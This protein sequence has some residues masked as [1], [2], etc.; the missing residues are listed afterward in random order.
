MLINDLKIIEELEIEVRLSTSVGRSG[1]N[2]HSTFLAR[3]C[4][5]FDAVYLAIGPHSSDIPD[6]QM[7][8]N[9]QIAINPLAF[10]TNMDKV[11]A[12]GDVL[13]V[14]VNYPDHELQHSAI[15]PFRWTPRRDFD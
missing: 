8:E 12:G 4:D 11:F 5:E 13:R 1:G 9:G 14:S 7:N 10:Q 2:G 3:L 15:L 6:L